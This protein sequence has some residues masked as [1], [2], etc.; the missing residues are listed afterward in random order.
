MWSFLVRDNNLGMVPLAYHVL[1]H[2]GL[3]SGLAGWRFQ[4]VL[5]PQQVGKVDGLIDESAAMYIL[6]AENGASRIS[7]A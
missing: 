5:G 6:R 7:D 4:Q 1:E 2:H 3:F